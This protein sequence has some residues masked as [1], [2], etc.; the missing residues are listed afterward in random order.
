M[1]TQ[2]GFLATIFVGLTGMVT[3]PLG[4]WLSDRFGRKPTMIVPW[5]VLLFSAVPGFFLLAHFRITGALIGMTIALT[6]AAG[7]ASAS[8]LV[9]VT[10]ILPARVRAGSLGL[11]YAVAISNFGGSTQFTA[12]WLTKL[13][14]NPLAPAWYMT[15]WVAIALLAMLALP[16]TAP[17]RTTT[18]KGPGG[19]GLASDR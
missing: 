3:D 18:E 14:H 16:E 17:V 19:R 6:V 5:V 2:V 8:V 12:A 13:T 1:A 4:G 15:V 10:E 11:I 9:A 7:I